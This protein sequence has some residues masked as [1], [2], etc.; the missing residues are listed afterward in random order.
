MNILPSIY[1]KVLLSKNTSQQNKVWIAT[2][3][4][5]D[6]WYLEWKWIGKPFRSRIQFQFIPDGVW[7]QAESFEED[8]LPT[9]KFAKE[10]SK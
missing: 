4:K 3:L 2:S 5:F 1:Q 10:C 6:N 9:Y 8:L 7:V